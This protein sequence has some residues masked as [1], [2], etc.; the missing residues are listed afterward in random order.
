VVVLVHEQPQQLGFS[1]GVPAT[2]SIQ[3][4]EQREVGLGLIL[5]FCRA[6][7]LEQ[8]EIDDWRRRGGEEI[9]ILP[10]GRGGGAPEQ[11]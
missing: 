9:E 7:D 8:D 11:A 5:I 10:L 1:L 3:G 6:Y 4:K 2:A